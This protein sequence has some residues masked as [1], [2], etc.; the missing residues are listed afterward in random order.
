M[1]VVKAFHALYDVVLNWLHTCSLSFSKKIEILVIN[2]GFI[3]PPR[4][5]V[6]LYPWEKLHH[7]WKYTVYP[8]PLG[9][10][11]K[12]KN[13]SHRHCFRWSENTRDEWAELS[14]SGCYAGPGCIHSFSHYLI[15]GHLVWRG[16][17][18]GHW[19]NAKPRHC[20]HGLARQICLQ[21]SSV[22]WR[23]AAA[24]GVGPT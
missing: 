19:C 1:R 24:G 3:H 16:R 2:Q 7:T 17:E 18:I 14:W 4:R 20:S 22:D 5:G 9:V 21:W 10:E 15:T 23:Y 13:S 11:W 12:D 8:P 6:S